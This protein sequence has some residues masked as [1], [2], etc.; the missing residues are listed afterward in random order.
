MDEGLLS[1]EEGRYLVSMA[2]K[3]IEHYLSQGDR[4][5]LK[6]SDLPSSERLV[7]DGACFVTLYS[8]R[9]GRKQLR[10][11]IGTLEANRPLIFD[12]I[13]NALNSAFGDPVSLHCARKSS[14][15]S[16]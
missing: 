6:P 12:V 3:A 16:R 11:C 1:R 15:A 13:D 5:E 14:T 10:G 4:L 8:V 7:G 2:R 9:G